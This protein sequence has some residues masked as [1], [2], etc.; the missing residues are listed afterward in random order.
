MKI[1][2]DVYHA[3][4]LII[5]PRITSFFASLCH[6]TTCRQLSDPVRS[7]YQSFPTI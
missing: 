5:H 2:Q 7:E 4:G 3:L 6:L 1:N